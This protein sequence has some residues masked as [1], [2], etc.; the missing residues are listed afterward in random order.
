MP[1]ADPEPCVKQGPIGDLDKGLGRCRGIGFRG[2]G[3]S[4]LG[5]LGLR[6]LVHFERIKP[7][8]HAECQ[9]KPCASTILMYRLGIPLL[10]IN[11]KP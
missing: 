7:D 4:G 8:Y 3:F 11:P 6:I 5:A 10:T 1:E 9:Y 2:K